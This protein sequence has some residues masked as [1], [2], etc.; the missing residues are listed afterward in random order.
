MGTS[1]FKHVLY[2]IREPN[3]LKG[4]DFQMDWHIDWLHL[5]WPPPPTPCIF[6]IELSS[7]LFHLELI[8]TMW[9]VYVNLPVESGLYF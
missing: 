2:T 3:K 4:I 6:Y 1:T 5:N 7:G 8:F 9:K